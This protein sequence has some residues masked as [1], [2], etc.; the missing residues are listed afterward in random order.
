MN[1]TKQKIVEALCRLYKAGGEPVS[2]SIIAYRAGISPARCN[3]ILRSDSSLA[4]GAAIPGLGSE[5]RY[6][7]KKGLDSND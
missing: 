2:T 3:I 7:P 5:L 4:D 6:I 1:K